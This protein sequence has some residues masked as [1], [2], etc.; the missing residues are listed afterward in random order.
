MGLSVIYY[1]FKKYNLKTLHHCHG[2]SL[3]YSN[4]IL[5]QTSRYINKVS[6]NSISIV[7]LVIFNIQ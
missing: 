6:L 3:K 2:E 7:N 1:L 5:Y 4:T